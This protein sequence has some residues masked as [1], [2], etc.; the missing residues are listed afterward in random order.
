MKRTY[1]CALFLLPTMI[2]AYSDYSV[3][4]SDADKYYSGKISLKEYTDSICPQNNQQPKT[5]RHNDGSWSKTEPHSNGTTTI[6]HS[7]G[8]SSRAE[9]HQQ[10][11]VA[12]KHSDGSWSRY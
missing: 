10:G 5:A 12:I 2:Y 6:K 9:K 8:T 11:S 7:N 4:E 1:F 3:Y